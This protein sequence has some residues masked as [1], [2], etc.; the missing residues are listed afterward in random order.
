M[1]ISPTKAFQADVLRTLERLRKGRLKVRIP[2][3][4]DLHRRKLGSQFHDKP[5]L[6]IQTGGATDFV[7][8]ADSFRLGVG[9]VCIMPRGVPHAETPQ[10]LRTPYGVLVCMQ[11]R[12]GFFLHRG[13][14]D[15]AH[16]IQGYGTIHVPGKR[17][18]FSYL[19]DAGR[20]EDLAPDHRKAYVR[21]L[22]EAFF[23]TILSELRLPT[24]APQS[25]GS[26]L[27]VE[28]EKYVRTHIGSGDLSVAALAKAMG[29]TAD[30]LSR[31]FHHE[32]GV[33]LTTWIAIERISM[34]KEMLKDM[35][36][37]VAEVG[38]CCGFKDTS[39]FIRI[40]KRHVGF[41][42]KDYRRGLL[43]S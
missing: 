7:C 12:N 35:R 37:N 5:E 29:R 27:V 23:L 30:H 3:E 1:K 2:R 24:P 26:A 39:H 10:D 8:P 33:K 15:P 41:T 9:E 28:T 17:D 36:Y 42:P 19:D 20:H 43:K 21:S 38:W 25:I 32:R 34:A 4:Q 31:Q 16:R 13:R 18:F 22:L 6:F 11:D 40:F 14:S